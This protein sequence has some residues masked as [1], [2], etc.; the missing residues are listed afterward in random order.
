[1]QLVL[2]LIVLSLDAQIGDRS[3]WRSLISSGV[4]GSLEFSA[5]HGAGFG[6]SLHRRRL[7]DEFFSLGVSVVD[8][9][10]RGR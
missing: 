3:R 2:A 4:E 9:R 1:M 10:S 8:G 6:L 7:S 5:T